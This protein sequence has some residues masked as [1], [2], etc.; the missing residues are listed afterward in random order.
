ML[1]INQKVAEPQMLRVT[2]LE[3]GKLLLGEEIRNPRQNHEPFIKR[4]APSMTLHEMSRSG[5]GTKLD[6]DS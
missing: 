6:I 1:D 5:H 2:M 4:G 3:D